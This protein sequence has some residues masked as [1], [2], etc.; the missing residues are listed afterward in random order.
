ML[1]LVNETYSITERSSS[2]KSL[3]GFNVKPSTSLIMHSDMCLGQ[4]SCDGDKKD[5]S[6]NLWGDGSCLT[7]VRSIS[8]IK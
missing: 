6:L 7:Y 8:Y 5:V 4:K 3:N 2:P 1:I